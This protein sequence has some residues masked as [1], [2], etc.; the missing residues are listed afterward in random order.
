MGNYTS[1]PGE[2]EIND[3]KMLTFSASHVKHVKDKYVR[4]EEDIKI[5]QFQVDHKDQKIPN[6]KTTSQLQ[7]LL[8]SKQKELDHIKRTV[9][10]MVTE[11]SATAK[12]INELILVQKR[13]KKEAKSLSSSMVE[14]QT[15][16]HVTT[17]LKD[18]ALKD[19]NI[20]T[21]RIGA[22]EQQLQAAQKNKKQADQFFVKEKARWAKKAQ[23]YEQVPENH[24]FENREH[25]IATIQQKYTH[26]LIPL[27][28]SRALITH[29]LNYFEAEL[30]EPI[31][32]EW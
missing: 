19:K 14:L 20:L 8:V 17:T 23:Q 16:V 27:S 10:D 29:C 18:F 6:T 32:N 11:K 21:A 31:D 3:E 7:T 26:N 5:L 4:S 12:E 24:F 30:F 13:L 1:T 2:S 25:H 28:I 15:Q 9:R 22:M